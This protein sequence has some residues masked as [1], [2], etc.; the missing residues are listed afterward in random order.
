[1]CYLIEPPTEGGYIFAQLCYSVPSRICLLPFKA[2]SSATVSFLRHG[3]HYASMMSCAKLCKIHFLNPQK[4]YP[5]PL[6]QVLPKDKACGMRHLFHHQHENNPAAPFSVGFTPYTTWMAHCQAHPNSR[7]QQGRPPQAGDMAQ[8]QL[9]K[10]TLNG[11]EI[12]EACRFCQTLVAHNGPYVWLTWWSLSWAQSMVHH[13][14]CMY[15]RDL[16][17]WSG[18]GVLG[19]AFSSLHPE[20]W[21]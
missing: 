16:I 14:I 7:S 10:A 12:K 3:L 19:S 6:H 5:C 18:G 11:S 4:W 20:V 15:F 17:E 1:M 2:I 21:L 8:H 13:R 9:E